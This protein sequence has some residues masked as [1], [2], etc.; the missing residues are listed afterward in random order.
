MR[1]EANVPMDEYRDDGMTNGSLTARQS[2]ELYWRR[3][4]D[5][6]KMG[7]DPHTMEKIQAYKAFR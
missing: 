4:S 5:P 2:M 6:D 3:G 1:L 7:P